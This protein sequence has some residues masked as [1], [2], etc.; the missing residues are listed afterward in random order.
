VIGNE[1]E[2]GTQANYRRFAAYEAHGRSRLYEELTQGVAAD[3]E[4]LALLDELPPD[5][6]QPNLLLATV[7]YLADVQPDYSAFRT[8]VLDR[9]DE[10]IATIM[11]RR[12]QTN[13]P[14]RCATL[15]P[16][17]AAFPQPLA[18]LE[19][20]ASA[21]LCLLPDRYGYD[22]DGHLVHGYPGAP[23]FTCQPRGPV[24]LPTGLPT[25]VW[26][27]GIDLHP[28]DVTNADDIDWLTCLVWPGETGR[29]EGLAAALAVARADPPRIVKGDLIEELAQ[30][31]AGAP[32][33]ATLVVFHSAVLTY[34]P[35]HRRAEF[36]AAVADLDAVWL[37]NEAPRVL[38]GLPFFP[39]VLPKP[40]PGP[41]PSVL[42]RNGKDVLA[43]LDGHGSW[44]R[45]LA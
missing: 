10:V 6:R 28:L 34:L 35:Q 26:R 25:V 20:G 45:W 42:T 5:K 15:L 11:V 23:V 38:A 44:I 8:V 1:P 17:L 27:A 16:A 13:E 29:A 19:V 33:E 22:Y 39:S 12:T 7:R 9:R 36:A 4:V 31:A 30:T 41:T 18:L 21:G 40:D 2:L 14:A 24:P 37:S 3:S 43:Y 32:P